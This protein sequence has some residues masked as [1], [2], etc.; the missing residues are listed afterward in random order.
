MALVSPVLWLWNDV[1]RVIAA[2]QVV[3]VAVGAWPLYELA[4]TLLDKSLSARERTQIWQLEP[5]RQLTRPM[6]LALA[7]AYLLT[8]HLQSALLTEFH[9]APLAV[10]LILWTFW[11]IESRRWGHFVY[12]H[13]P[14]CRRQ[15]RNGPPCRWVRSVAILAFGGSPLGAIFG[16][17]TSALNH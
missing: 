7:L 11:A 12:A 13:S 9:A 16:L 2:P 17:Q 10:P 1:R 4:L 14:R 3:L 5:L 6:A 15:R 8:P